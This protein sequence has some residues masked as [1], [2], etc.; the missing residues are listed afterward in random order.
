MIRNLLARHRCE[1]TESTVGIPFSADK[2][3]DY[4]Q[5]LK[6]AL[7]EPRLQRF[8]LRETYEQV[9]R[10]APE[11][12][13]YW[14]IAERDMFMEWYDPAT[15][16]FGLAHRVEGSVNPVSIGVRGDLVGVF[17]AM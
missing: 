6:A 1:P 4:V 16:D 11:Y 8:E 10:H 14:V 17:A 3:S 5:E 7:I 15:G 12:A 9:V 2:M 13:D